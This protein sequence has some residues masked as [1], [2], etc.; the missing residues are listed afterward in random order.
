[1]IKKIAHITD[2][3]L[4][5]EFSIGIK[6]NT[7]KRFDMILESIKENEINEIIC[8]GDIGI[9]KGVDY[10]FERLKNMNLSVTMG[11]HDDFFE[12]SK[13]YSLGADYELNKIYKSRVYGQYKFIYLDSST[14]YIDDKQIEWLKTE[15]KSSRPLMIFVHHPIFATGLKIDEIGQLNNS[16]ELKKLLIEVPRP[17]HIFCGHYHMES[18]LVHKNIAQQITPAVVFQ[19]KKSIDKIDLDASI[20][21][22]RIIEIKNSELSSKVVYLNHAD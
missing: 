14:G 18:S 16:N 12:I 15:L 22:Y 2:L 6:I 7:R 10:F 17:I 5:E 3:H 11:N 9:N 20:S 1:M 8:T 21:G 19:V 13:Y 4:D